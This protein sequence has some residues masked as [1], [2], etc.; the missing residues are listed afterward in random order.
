MLLADL[1]LAVTGFQ[2][3]LGIWTLLEY[4]PVHLGSAHQVRAVQS[5]WGADWAWLKCDWAYR[6][7][8]SVSGAT[9]D[10]TTD[11]HGTQCVGSRQA[12]I[13]ELGAGASRSGI[14]SN[15]FDVASTKS[16]SSDLTAPLCPFVSI[17]PLTS[18][19]LLP[20]PLSV[21]PPPCPTPLPF[22]SAGQRAQ[23]VCGGARYTAHPAPRAAQRHS[24][25]A[26]T[27][28]HPSGYGVSWE[29]SSGSDA[30]GVKALRHS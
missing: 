18:V 2:F 21:P 29:H 14:R 9:V 26:L 23:P 15:A 6:E 25:P 22:T 19:S 5:Q 24:C 11:M 30:A 4:V 3:L 1:V 28:G 8:L 20:A 13:T 12:V 16:T 10:Q 7:A 17:S 27:C